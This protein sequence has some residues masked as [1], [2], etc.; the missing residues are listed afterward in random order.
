MEEEA[1]YQEFAVNQRHF[2]TQSTVSERTIKERIS[3]HNNNK[4]DR[5]SSQRRKIA[6]N[7]NQSPLLRQQQ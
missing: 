2:A 4:S 3:K 7:A 1:A 5:K 6:V